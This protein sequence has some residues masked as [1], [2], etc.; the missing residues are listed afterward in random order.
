[1]R[2]SLT[3]QI[4]YSDVDSSFRIRPSG[5]LR[6]FQDVSALHSELTGSGI[7]SLSEQGVTWVLGKLAIDIQHYPEY[8]D[9]LRIISWSRSASG[10]RMLRDF[11]L[12]INS[13]RVGGGSSVWFY[14]D[15]KVGK[16]TRVPAAIDH[17]YG[18]DPH[19]ARAEGVERWMPYERFDPET[20]RTYTPG[21]FDLDAGGHVN[22]AR[23][24]DY[25][26]DAAH[27]LVDGSVVRSTR[28]QFSRE[29]T[30]NVPFEIGVRRDGDSVLFKLRNST[31]MFARGEISLASA[32]EP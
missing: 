20:A 17:A 30:S 25:V 16:V 15:R 9:E 11:E 1:M 6:L 2:V 22:N 26:M 31:S 18:T 32:H 24:V 23:Y 7:R 29:I 8:R 10:F 14:F 27:D 12:E 5:L 13:K 3:H 28:I 19:L 21:I 4:H